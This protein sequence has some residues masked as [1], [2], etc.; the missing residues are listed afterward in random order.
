MA[1]E[2]Y[3]NGIGVDLENRECEHGRGERK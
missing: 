2:E 1:V 3:L